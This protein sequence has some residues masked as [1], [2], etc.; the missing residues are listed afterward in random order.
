MGARDEFDREQPLIAIVEDKKH[1]SSASRSHCKAP[2][3]YL[4]E[5]DEY[6]CAF[7]LGGK[8]SDQGSI[9]LLTGRR[10]IF[11]AAMSDLSNV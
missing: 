4:Y 9:P 3:Q 8:K 10:R 5:G 11:P 7:N 2:P 1:H 6:D